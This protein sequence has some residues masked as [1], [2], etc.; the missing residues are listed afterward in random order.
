MPAMILRWAMVGGLLAAVACSSPPA[1]QPPAAA[2]DVNP[3][4]LVKRMS[5]TLAAARTFSFSTTEMHERR[6][7]TGKQEL[8]FSRTHLVRRPNGVA[9]TLQGS[10]REGLGAYDGEHFTLV[11]TNQKAY[12]KVKMPPT[13]DAALDRLAEHF[14]MPMPVGDLLYSNPY[15]RF[16][17][18]A[19]GR[20]AGRESIGGKDCEHLAYSEPQ[21]DWQI[22][23][24]ASG[25]P[26]PCQLEIT[27][28][29]QSGPL[30]SRVAFAD[31]NLAAP[32]PEGAFAPKVPDGF[33]RILMM[34]HEPEASPAA[35]AGALAE[36]KVP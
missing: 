6:K 22:W 13:I 10:E 7:G 5:D 32:V 1:A 34:A 24:A 35:S 21:V 18:E 29:G 9:F 31:W 36:G 20:Y 11:W 28:K 17:G 25:D 23:I 2:A 16:M 33:E 14:Q 8:R 3:E 15:E 12:A 19:K 30:T 26:L 4:A 27:S